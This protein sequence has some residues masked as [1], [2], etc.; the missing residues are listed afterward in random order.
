MK[1][2]KIINPASA[3]IVMALGIFL[4]GAIEAFPFVDHYL[5]KGL[6]V[7]L[8]LIGGVVYSALV[9]QILRRNFLIPF[10][11]N[12]VN[13]FVMGAWIAGMSVLCNVM[14]KYFPDLHVI[15]Q[16]I[17]IINTFFLFLFLIWCVYN[18]KRLWDRPA[19]H[20]THG[21]VLLS[22]VAAQSVVIVWSELFPFVSAVVVL[23]VVSLGLIFYLL[24][25]LLIGIR[26]REDPKWSLTEDWSNTNCI[27]HGALSITGLALVSTEMM[28]SLFYLIF[29]LSVFV[30]VLSIETV[31]VRRAVKRVQAYGWKKGIFTYNISQWSRNFTFGMFY[32]FTMVRHDQPYYLNTMYELHEVFL[33]VWAWVVLSALIIQVGLW[34]KEHFPMFRKGD[35][36]KAV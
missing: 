18:F 29:W 32:A 10:L 15:V 14:L 7:M 28:S 21:V 25:V 19:Q 30:A 6:T 5:G 16:G 11:N 9:R 23:T 26:Y 20:A 31:E 33:S 4:Y 8:V 36:Q 35:G 22:T 13:S 2:I 17:T 24:G 12:P 27:I 1:D 34:T 3:A